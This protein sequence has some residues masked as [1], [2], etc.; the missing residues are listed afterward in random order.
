MGDIHFLFGNFKKAEKAYK[1]ALEKNE[2]FDAPVANLAKIYLY[3]GEY[4]KALEMYETY[5]GKITEDAN[6][7]NVYVAI[8]QIYNLIGNREKTIESYKKS[9]ELFLFNDEPIER[10]HE[11]YM[12]EGD[13]TAAQELLQHRYQQFAEALNTGT[14]PMASIAG[15]ISLSLMHDIN[16]TNSI[17]LLKGI[18]RFAEEPSQPIDKMNVVNIKFYLTLLYTKE[19]HVE[20]IDA[21]WEDGEIFPEETRSFISMVQDQSYSI[22]SAFIMLNEVFYEYSEE[23]ESFYNDLI[24]FSIENEAK[25]YEMAFRTF[26]ADVCIHAGKIHKVQEQLEIL[27]RPEERYWRV[28]GP[29]KNVNGF[30]KKYSPE[31][32]IDLNREYKEN[33]LKYTWQEAKDDE[34]DGFINFREIFDDYIWKIAYGLLYVESPVD[35]EIYLRFGSDDESK[36]WVNNK[37]VWGLM[38]R[39]PAYF[40]GF[41]IK[42]KLKKG[43]NKILVKVGNTIGNW[44]FFLRITDEFGNGIPNVNFVL[45]E[46]VFGS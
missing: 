41:V 30:H 1:K 29:F 40:D 37:E 11:L 3:L 45:P 28:I 34:T 5:L 42:A 25:K 26:L 23:G 27:G 38:Y 8:G 31:K 22:W 20:E 2:D 35:Q 39:G 46:A 33:G 16:I 4:D 12:D 44:G 14:M 43:M 10:L 6:K 15:M 7:S 17:E 13:T 21:L 36:V 32:K 19:N 9:A 18:L 24:K